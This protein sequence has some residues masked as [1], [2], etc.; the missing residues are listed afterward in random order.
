MA[1]MQWLGTL[2]GEPKGAAYLAQAIKEGTQAY[3]QT[4]L[5]KEKHALA[6]KELGLKEQQISGELQQ[7]KETLAYEKERDAAVLA[8]RKAQAESEA[9]RSIETLDITKKKELAN[10]L[11]DSLNMMDE[12]ASKEFLS[13]PIVKK[14]FESAGIP[15]PTGAFGIR[16][17]DAGWGGVGRGI[18][19]IGQGLGSWLGNRGKSKYKV[20]PIQP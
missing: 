19:A 10:T 17:K 1:Q 2:G 5:Q 12:K 15:V 16:P 14:V 13:Q 6:L 11:L 8:Q 20:T 4:R 9:M 7:H 18:E 3:V